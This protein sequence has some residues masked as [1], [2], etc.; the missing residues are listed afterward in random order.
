MKLAGLTRPHLWAA[1]RMLRFH[2]LFNLH[3]RELDNHINTC[4]ENGYHLL[5]NSLILLLS[6]KEPA[7]I[8]ISLWVYVMHCFYP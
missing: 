7:V 3:H 5:G 2:A 6:T 1:N 4:L 8:G